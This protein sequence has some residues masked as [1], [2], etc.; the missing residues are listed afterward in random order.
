VVHS[1]DPVLSVG[2][3]ALGGAL[4]AKFPRVDPD[5]EADQQRGLGHSQS[6]GTRPALGPQ[7]VGRGSETCCRA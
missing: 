4:A 3:T 7:S 2:S 6:P 1:G 5:A